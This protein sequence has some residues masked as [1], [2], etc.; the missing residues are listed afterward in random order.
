RRA[1]FWKATDK[2]VSD[3]TGISPMRLLLKHA[4]LFKGRI[5][6]RLGLFG[7]GRQRKAGIGLAK[8]K[9]RNGIFHGA[10]VCLD[11]ERFVQRHEP[12]MQLERFAEITRETRTLELCAELW[13]CVRGHGNASMSPVSHERKR[14]RVFAR[15]LIELF[16]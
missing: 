2:G 13:S 3:G 12:V 16:A 10:R 9:P 14:R 11:K 6:E 8:P 1:E 4:R 7:D 5:N 15:E